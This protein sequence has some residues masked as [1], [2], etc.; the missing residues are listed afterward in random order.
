[1]SPA[2]CKLLLMLNV[3]L[4]SVFS[5]IRRNCRGFSLN[6][7]PN[8]NKIYQKLLL[9]PHLKITVF[10]TTQIKMCDFGNFILLLFLKYLLYS[11]QKKVN[12]CCC[13]LFYF[14]VCNICVYIPGKCFASYISQGKR[15]FCTI[16]KFYRTYF[17][18]KY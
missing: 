4:N 13:Y 5:A 12:F 7:N 14:L 11:Y 1:M 8:P 17:F 18:S 16:T 10:R 15:G 6:P 3:K 9:L 2:F